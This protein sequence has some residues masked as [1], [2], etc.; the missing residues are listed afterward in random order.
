MIICEAGEAPR[1]RGQYGG[2]KLVS[3][4]RLPGFEETNTERVAT[5]WTNMDDHLVWSSRGSVWTPGGELAISAAGQGDDIF[6]SVPGR[7]EI[8]IRGHTAI[9]RFIAPVTNDALQA[10]LL[11]P[12]LI[13]LLA[14]R[15]QFV[16]HASA[17]STSDG[18]IILCGESGTG[19]STIA[20]QF[21]G[22]ALA[23]DLS[24]ASSGGTLPGPLPQLKWHPPFRPFAASP[25]TDIFFLNPGET[26]TPSTE[27]LSQG[28]ATLALCRHTVAARLFPAALLKAH[29]EWSVE[30]STSTRVWRLD[31][32]QQPDQIPAIKDRILSP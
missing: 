6:L 20:R 26:E 2:Q 32:R 11:G 17:I 18:A 13:L 21:A 10:V 15:G 30:L 8:A 29:L 27:R 24:C 7:M 31:Y 16:L 25:I 22:A 19:K 1:Y 23:D 3:S 14:A 12:V 4:I 5:V 9:Y 28:E